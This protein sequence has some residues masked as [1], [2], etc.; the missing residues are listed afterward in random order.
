MKNQAS[1][2]S[3]SLRGWARKARPYPP[4]TSCHNEAAAHPYTHEIT[5]DHCMLR[6]ASGAPPSRVWP[7]NL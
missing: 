4:A 5:R 2:G 6:N 7:W 3:G 1:T